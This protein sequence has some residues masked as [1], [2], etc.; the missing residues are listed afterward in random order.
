VAD[1]YSGR[2]GQE[3]L[4]PPPPLP[5]RHHSRHDYWR[6]VRH[7]YDRYSDHWFGGAYSWRRF[8]RGCYSAPWF[9]PCYSSVYTYP[10]VF[11]YYDP[12]AY[13]SFGWRTPYWHGHV[14]RPW[15]SWCDAP[16]VYYYYRYPARFSIGLNFYGD[17]YYAGGAYYDDAAYYDDGVYYDDT[18]YYYSDYDIYSGGSTVVAAA[19]DRPVGVWVPGHWEEQYVV[20]TEWVWVPGHYVY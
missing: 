7:H 1:A 16:Y 19:Y 3:F 9:Y 11:G 2:R 18:G 13:V 17:D 6:D 5:G 15:W 14:Y 4:P 10:W 12:F 20:D 8:I